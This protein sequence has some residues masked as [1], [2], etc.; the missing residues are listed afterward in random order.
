[1]IVVV[2]TGDD[3]HWTCI[4]FMELCL[5]SCAYVRDF[6]EH[7]KRYSLPVQASSECV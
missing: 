7:L 4:G 6:N 2:E 3:L 1:M 5:R